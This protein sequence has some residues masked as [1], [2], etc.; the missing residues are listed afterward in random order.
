MCQVICVADLANANLV[1][2]VLMVIL[3]NVFFHPCTNNGLFF[4]HTNKFHIFPLIK[5]FQNYIN[6]LV[7]CDSC[8]FVDA[9]FSLVAYHQVFVT[10]V[11]ETKSI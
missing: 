2:P 9:M 8:A 6:S 1:Y 3:M 7:I 11:T 4:L 10:I 5:R